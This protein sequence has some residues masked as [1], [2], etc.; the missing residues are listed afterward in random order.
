MPNEVTIVQSIAKISLRMRFR[1]TY[2]KK[3][4]GLNSSLNEQRVVKIQFT[5]FLYARR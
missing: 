2:R 1:W 3:K 5:K 4:F